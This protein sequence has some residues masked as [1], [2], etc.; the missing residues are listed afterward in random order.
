MTSC[1]CGGTDLVEYATAEDVG[2]TLAVLVEV[3]RHE[4][5]DAERRVVVH[6]QLLSTHIR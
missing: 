6:D 3:E 2:A 4:R 1:R 5:V